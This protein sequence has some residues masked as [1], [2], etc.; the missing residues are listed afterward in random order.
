MKLSCR[1]EVLPGTSVLEKFENARRFGFEGIGLPGRFL[2][3]YLPE[4]ERE[5]ASLPVPA[6]SLSLGFESSILHP[7]ATERERCRVSLRRMMDLCQQLG[8]ERFN[9]PPSLLQD[10]PVRMTDRGEFDSVEARLDNLLLD[11]LHEIGDEA[12]ER[13]VLFL[14]EPVNR[15]ESDYL[16]TI[17]HGARLV[18]AL[19]HSAVAMTV[20]SFHMQMEELIP[21]ESILDAAETIRHVHVAENTR[22]EPGLG[23]LDFDPIFRALREVGYD[24]GI[25]IECRSLSGEAESVLP[26][27]VAYLRDLWQWA[28]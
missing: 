2:N 1:L 26:G 14:I 12:S 11:Q 20:D 18:R 19:G 16:N 10:N 5:L 22:V 9:V 8:V 23:S 13:G 21:S 15:F 24:D 17:K 3:E 25:E 6:T 27:S 7:E 28:R 4:L